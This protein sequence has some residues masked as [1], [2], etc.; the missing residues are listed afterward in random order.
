MSETENNQVYSRRKK[1]TPSKNS[2]R[3]LPQYKNMPQEEF[4]A[5]FDDNSFELEHDQ[6]M[7]DRVD[8]MYKQFEDSYDL[9][10]LMPNDRAV[11]F[12]MIRDIIRLEDL[13]KMITSE[14]KNITPDNI[15]GIKLLSEITERLKVSISKAQDDLKISRKVRK[16]DKEES[17]LAYLEDLKIKSKKFYYRKHLLILCPKCNELLFSGRWLYPDYSGNKVI[18]SCHRKFPDGNYCDGHVEISS[19]ELLDR[20]GSNFP[21]RLPEALR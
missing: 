6:E 8:S 16:S 1:R 14:S 15:L 12:S 4:D 9:S 19:K 11:L 17:V 3:N 13:D 18:L 5:M 2:L 20:G 7:Q 10:E 21:D